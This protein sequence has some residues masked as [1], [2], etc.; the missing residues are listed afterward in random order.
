MKPVNSWYLCVCAGASSAGR[1]EKTYD[2]I[3]SRHTGTAF[4][5]Q[6]S[7]S[8]CSVA[9]LCS[10]QKHKWNP[11]C[12][13]DLCVYGRASADVTAWSTSCCIRGECTQ[14]D[15]SHWHLKTSRLKEEPCLV[16]AEHPFIK[17]REKIIKLKDKFVDLLF[18]QLLFAWVYLFSIP[19]GLWKPHVCVCGTGRWRAWVELGLWGRCQSWLN[20]YWQRKMSFQIK[21]NE[22]T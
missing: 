22:V 15:V 17:K 13:S 21:V 11:S 19:E 9:T 18:L 16:L 7:S 6:N 14:K 2:R 3:L 12:R 10:E 5:L 8:F 4:L 1:S 20:C